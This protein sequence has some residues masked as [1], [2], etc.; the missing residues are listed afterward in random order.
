MKT[1]G[2]DMTQGCFS[3]DWRTASSIRETRKNS[4]NTDNSEN[5]KPRFTSDREYDAYWEILG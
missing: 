2:Y 1:N 4:M 5:S 3:E